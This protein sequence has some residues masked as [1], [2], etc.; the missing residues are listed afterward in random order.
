MTAAER[1]RRHRKRRAESCAPTWSTPPHVTA[2]VLEAFGR[3]RFCLDPASPDPAVT[4]CERFYSVRH[5]GLAHPWLGELVW[6]NPP[7]GRG[8]LQR[9]ILKA[10]A[11]QQAGNAR[12]L[13][14]L[15][16]ARMETEGTCRLAD[17]GAA[18]FVLRKRL[19]F[20]N[21]GDRAPWASLVAVLGAD[22]GEL[23]AL[24]RLLPD[25]RRIA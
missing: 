8:Q 4:P 11:E 16:P 6:C 18:M 3:E 9:W 21:A 12:K 20:G 2:A 24:G 19:A 14:L 23:E 25:N 1:M 17:I 13:A 7:Y 22:A 10:I 15:V 5:D